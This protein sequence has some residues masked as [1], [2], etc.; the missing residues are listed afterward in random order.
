MLLSERLTFCFL[1][2][3]PALLAQAPVVTSV[4]NEA[5]GE[6]RFSPGVRAIVEVQN[7]GWDF[8]TW[9]V[10]VG[11]REAPI[12][13]GFD[14]DPSFW[15]VQLPL[16]LAPGPTTVVASAG[17]V[18]SPPFA[19]TLEP[20]APGILY[21][22]RPTTPAMPDGRVLTLDCNPPD[23]RANPGDILSAFA[24]GLGATDPAVATGA[25][26]TLPFPS[27]VAKPAITVGGRDAEV[28]ESVLTAFG[29]YRLTFRVPPETPNGFHPVVLS[30]GGYNGSPHG[31]PVGAAMIHGYPSFGKQGSTAP[32]T[33]V[34][35]YACGATFSNAGPAGFVGD[36]RNP[37]AALGGT[38][39][40]VKDSV[41]VER[42]APL[43]YVG[44]FQVNYIVPS[45]TVIG[46][47]TVTATSID[48]AVST[49]SLEIRAV[50]PQLYSGRS[51]A[52]AAV[53]VRLRDGAQ[54]EEPV[55]RVSASG[56]IEIAPIDMGPET[57]QL[58]LLL[59]GTGLRGRSSLS[60]VS[61]RIGGVEAPVLYAGPQGEFQA[62]DQV[63]VRLPRS[64][65]GRGRFQEVRLI[66]DGQSV[67]GGSL[68][69]E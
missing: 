59:F 46:T 11:G 28:L 36:A 45:G 52:P 6:A 35:A 42:L 55:E 29:H 44:R 34:V 9:R 16:E 27:T 23:R 66:V 12:V 47:A 8:T 54:H 25:L 14:D 4:R 5:S 63:N 49:G 51:G 37:P 50:A 43:L 7:F 30:I 56:Q 32:D 10:Q 19:I 22:Q 61:V 21:F 1:L 38:T 65:A 53:L 69:F 68:S 67:S 33:I 48:G 3:Q 31:L 24:V 15:V 20:Y 26:P 18:P 13:G 17:N 57:D 2:I 60:A 39:V 41:G 62:L 40:K 64:L 58:Y